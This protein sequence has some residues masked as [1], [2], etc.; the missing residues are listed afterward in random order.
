M[1]MA[2]SG[3][4]GGQVI[5]EVDDK[6]AGPRHEG[7]RPEDMAASLNRCLGI[8]R[9]EEYLTPTGR[10]VMIVRHGGPIWQLFG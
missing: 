9:R 8:D 2:G 3:I 10:P 6:K 5:G 1:L 7:I 4:W